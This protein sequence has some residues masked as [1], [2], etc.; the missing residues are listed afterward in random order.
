MKWEK[1]FEDE[2]TDNSY[3]NSA[4]SL[5]NIDIIEDLVEKYLGKLVR[6]RPDGYLDLGIKVRIKASKGIILIER[7]GK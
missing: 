3:L 4:I 2:L 1:E 7:I 5:Q 6:S